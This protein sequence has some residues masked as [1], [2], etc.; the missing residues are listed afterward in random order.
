MNPMLL[1]KKSLKPPLNRGIYSDMPNAVRGKNSGSF[2]TCSA[3]MLSIVTFALTN[4][5]M[6]VKHLPLKLKL[7]P[8]ISQRGRESES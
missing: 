2:N 3:M 1:K 4:T 8:I 5:L 7:K 6:S